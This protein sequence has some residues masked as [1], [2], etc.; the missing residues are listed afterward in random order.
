MVRDLAPKMVSDLAN[1]IRDGDVAAARRHAHTLKNS[2][3]NIAAAGTR[4]LS[5]R[6]E[7]LLISRDLAGAAAVLDDL[8]AEVALTRTLVEFGDSVPA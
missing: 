4:D 3:D 7:Q 5:F 6:I 1:A 8:R 2:A